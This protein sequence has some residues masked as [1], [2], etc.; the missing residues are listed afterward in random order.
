MLTAVH[1]SEERCIINDVVPDVS[2]VHYVAAHH[3]DCTPNVCNVLAQF[4]AFTVN[5]STSRVADID[6][7]MDNLPMRQ[8]MR[9][10]L[11]EL[12]TSLWDGACRFDRRELSAHHRF[13]A[14]E[15]HKRHATTYRPW[16]KDARR[17]TNGERAKKYYGRP[18]FYASEFVAPVSIDT[19]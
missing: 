14:H 7:P 12:Y 17:E 15:C 19:L 10:R 8:S 5:K 4:E 18:A 13:P 16:R 11:I 1:V 6:H 3:P 9:E 2:T